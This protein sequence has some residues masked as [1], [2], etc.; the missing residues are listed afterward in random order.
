[1]Y[2]VCSRLFDISAT[3]T[4]ECTNK[5]S[6]PL[7]GRKQSARYKKHIPSVWKGFYIPHKGAKEAL[8]QKK[9]QFLHVSTKIFHSWSNF[10][11]NHQICELSTLFLYKHTANYVLQYSI[12]FDSFN[13]DCPIHPSNNVEMVFLSTSPSK[14]FPA[15]LMSETVVNVRWEKWDGKKRME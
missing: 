2:S 8:N 9:P 6:R 15:Y 4:Q 12:S 3:C 10:K 13:S 7:G 1:M 5:C 14:I 11:I